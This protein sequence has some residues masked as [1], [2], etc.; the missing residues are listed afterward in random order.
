MS[1]Q[2]YFKK[3]IFVHV[4]VL[5]FVMFFQFNVKI[6]DKPRINDI[7]GMYIYMYV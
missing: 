6:K 7:F 2:I 3:Y 1:F 5:A 4:Q